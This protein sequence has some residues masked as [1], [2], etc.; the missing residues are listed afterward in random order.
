MPR[1]SAHMIRWL[2][3]RRRTPLQVS[4]RAAVF[5][6]R[7]AHPAAWPA[8]RGRE[9]VNRCNNWEEAMSYRIAAGMVLALAAST[10]AL[11]AQGVR[12]D[13]NVSMDLAAAIMTAAMDRCSKDGY[14]VSVAVVDRAGHGRACPPQGLYGAHLPPF[15]A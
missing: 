3:S 5:R 6:V 7:R 9:S 4:A 12:M 2:A 15:V 10:P 8:H 1:C 14:Q 11:Q 13:R